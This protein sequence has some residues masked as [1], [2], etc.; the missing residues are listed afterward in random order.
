MLVIP[1]S[2]LNEL[3]GKLGDLLEEEVCR[4]DCFAV[5]NINAV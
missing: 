4:I 3:E 1:V 2:K 5:E